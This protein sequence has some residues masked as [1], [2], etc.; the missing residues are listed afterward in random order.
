MKMTT[1]YLTEKQITWFE[2]HPEISRSEVIR[3]ALDHFIERRTK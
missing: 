1:I 2:K 3:Q